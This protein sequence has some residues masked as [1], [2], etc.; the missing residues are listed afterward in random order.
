MLTGDLLRAPTSSTT[1]DGNPF[2]SGQKNTPGSI[3][4]AKNKPT[5]FISRWIRLGTRIE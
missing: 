1:I 4:R 3:E 2:S 5:E